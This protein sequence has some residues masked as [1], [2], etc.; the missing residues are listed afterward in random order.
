MKNV[1][2]YIDNDLY[3]GTW[4]LSLDFE[5]EH[6]SLKQTVKNN[7]KDII[8]VGE[9]EPKKRLVDRRIVE[10]KNYKKTAK[11]E[12]TNDITN[13]LS[14]RKKSMRLGPPIT[15][16]LLNEPQATFVIILLKGHYKKGQDYIPKV[17]KF[18]KH[19]TSQFFKQR[20]IL[21]KLLSQKQN[22]EWL[23]KRDSGKLERR[24]ETDAIKKFV[25]YCKIQG[26]KNAEKYYM[27]I[28][29][30]ENN[31][32]FF[33]EFIAQRNPNIREIAEGFQLDSLQMADRIVAR[34][35]VE[36]MERK[37]FYKDIFQ[38][39]KERVLQFA[40]VIGKTPLEICL[41]KQKLIN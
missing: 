23:A 20:K 10:S 39:S 9:V 34:A 41:S 3:V 22:A 40:K 37:M 27:I 25:D 33:F 26:S 36:G 12:K 35:L 18:K 15:E 16:Y 11:D 24:I 13:V 2:E 21:T 7:L 29:K 8:E 38:L 1:I 14:Q 5:V 30:M 32:L 31:S 28:S 19:L 17:V 6:R 4:N